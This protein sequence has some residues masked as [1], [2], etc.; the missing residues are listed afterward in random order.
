MTKSLI[1]SKVQTFFLYFTLLYSFTPEPITIYTLSLSNAV[2]AIYIAILTSFYCFTSNPIAL[3]TISV[4]KLTIFMVAMG[5]AMEVCF[6]LGYS[7]VTRGT[8]M[9][10]ETP[11]HGVRGIIEYSQGSQVYSNGNWV[12]GSSVWSPAMM[13]C[14]TGVDGQ[15]T[16][17]E[18][19]DTALESYGLWWP[20]LHKWRLGHS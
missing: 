16:V 3:C 4:A 2:P 7:H 12:C 1:F 10:S 15:G 11:S 14:G 19:G 6:S 17:A 20:Y 18:P 13:D 8:E 5:T 9:S